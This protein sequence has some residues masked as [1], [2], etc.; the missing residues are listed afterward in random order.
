MEGLRGHEW[1]CSYAAGCTS[2][3]FFFFFA[4]YWL[5]YE[6]SLFFYTVALDTRANLRVY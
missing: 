3:F 6:H 2:A 1:L 5:D 4:W